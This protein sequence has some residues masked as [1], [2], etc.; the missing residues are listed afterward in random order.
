[1]KLLGLI[2][3]KLSHSFSEKYFS[4]KFRK[5]NITDYSYRLFPL[6]NLTRLHHFITDNA[7]LV[8]FNVTIPFKQQIINYLD[9]LDPTSREVGAVNTVSILRK[10]HSFHLKGYNTD[11]HGFIRSFDFPKSTFQA[12]ILG[13]GGAAQAV[14]H[15]LKL[16]G[17]TSKFVSRNPLNLQ[18]LR[19]QDLTP[20]HFKDFQLIINATPAGMYPDTESFPPLPYQFLQ[21]ENI[22]Y[23]LVYNPE[24]TR[25]MQFGR[26]KGAQVINGLKMLELQAEESWNI[27]RSMDYI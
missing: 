5:E 18:I 4:E 17:V 24:T 6:E 23:D 9:E 22:L 13:T 25:F 7:D 12:L 3:Q 15:A 8:G 10:E 19:Y 26:E 11:A 16:L 2:G 14:Y 20:D 21:P 27:W 1:M